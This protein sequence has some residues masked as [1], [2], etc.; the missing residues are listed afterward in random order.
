[1]RSQIQ[2]KSLESPQVSEKPPLRKGYCFAQ[3]GAF[4]GGGQRMPEPP[5]VRPGSLRVH[6]CLSPGRESGEP[7]LLAEPDRDRGDGEGELTIGHWL[8]AIG[9]CPEAGNS[10]SQQPIVTNQ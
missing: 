4:S 3:K 8:L 9:Y 6:A 1:M 5:D 7:E 10:N 2:T